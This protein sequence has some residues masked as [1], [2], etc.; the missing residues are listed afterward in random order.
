M[1]RGQ[2]WAQLRPGWGV[3]EME[4]EKAAFHA[5]SIYFYEKCSFVSPLYFMRDILFK[6]LQ[7]L[8]WILDSESDTS[9][10]TGDC[11]FF[12]WRSR[13]AVSSPLLTSRNRGNLVPKWGS[14]KRTASQAAEAWYWQDL[15][16]SSI[17]LNM[18]WFD[19]IIVYDLLQYSININ[20]PWHP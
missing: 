17:A 18:T 19:L 9:T 15:K 8:E 12:L 4:R 14:R 2:I 7:G 1:L 13:D 3:R 16:R 5:I 11:S 6:N 10:G 20:Q